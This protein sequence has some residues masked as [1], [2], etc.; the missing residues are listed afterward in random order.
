MSGEHLDIRYI[1]VTGSKKLL[2]SSR[3]TFG[4]ENSTRVAHLKEGESVAVRGK[5]DGYGKNIIF[6]DCELV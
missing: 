4:K 1:M 3:C 2:W 6:K 5:Y